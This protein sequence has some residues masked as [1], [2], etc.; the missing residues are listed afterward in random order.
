MV[1]YLPGCSPI[2]SRFT[3][4][5]EVLAEDLDFFAVA[6]LAAFAFFEEAWDD[7]AA[8]ELLDF[9][10]VIFAM[11]VCGWARQN[12]SII[13]LLYKPIDMICLHL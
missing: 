2:N 7:W 4:W 13:H 1:A 3:F 8:R 10:V 6:S 12:T 9:E 11:K 5:A